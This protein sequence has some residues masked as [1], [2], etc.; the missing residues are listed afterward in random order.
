MLPSI[1]VVNTDNPGQHFQRKMSLSDPGAQVHDMDFKTGKI[2]M[3]IKSSK[4]HLAYILYPIMKTKSLFLTALCAD[5]IFHTAQSSHLGPES[6]KPRIQ[7]HEN[8]PT[9]FTLHT[10]MRMYKS[11]QVGF[12]NYK[13]LKTEDC[14][15]SVQT[16]CLHRKR[17]FF[18]F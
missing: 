7:Y 18:R 9:N 5:E 3:A 8:V 11:L 12:F 6:L 15:H 2:L 14:F 1:L 17:L 4:Y 10:K 16:Q 13:L